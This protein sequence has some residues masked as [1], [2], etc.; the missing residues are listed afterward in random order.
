MHSVDRSEGQA[1]NADTAALADP[2]GHGAAEKAAAAGGLVLLTLAA[3]QFLMALDSSVMNV[4]IA[5]VANDV[6]TTV[7]GI[8]TAI[9]LY[10][11]VM[12]TTM[13]VGGKIGALIGRRRAFAIGC[14][15]YGAGSLTTALAPNLTVLLLGWSL[16]EGLGA[17]LIM[18][19]I[20]A[21][22]AANFAA[23]L[24]P[25][26]YGLVAAAGAMAIAVG[27][28]LGG[29]VTT[30]FSWRW[31]FAGEVVVVIGI[32]ALARRIHDRPAPGKV[33]LDVRGAVLSACGLAL[34][35]FGVLRSS[36]WGWVR[37]KAGAP[38]LLGLSPTLW[39]VLA[40]GLVLW[41]FFWWQ[42]RLQDTGREPLVSPDLLANRQL[43]GGLVMF[44]FQFLV[45]MGVFFTVPLF[46]SVVLGLTALQ[47]GLRLLPLSIALLIA[48]AGIPRLFPRV[49]PRLI[50]RLGLSSMLAGTVVLLAGIDLDASAAVVLLPMLLVG[51][52]IGALAS[53]L[54]SV[55]V[56]AVPDD[57]S[58]EVGGVQN[59]VTNLG[60][61]FGTALAGSILIAVL[62][63]SFI[64]GI[65]Q[66]PAVPDEVKTQ[67]S[68]ELA[69]GVPFV[70]DADLE[71]ALR[72][73][74]ADEALTQSVVADNR[75]ARVDGLDAALAVIALIALIG[76]F[77]TR[78]VPA[79]QPGAAEADGAP[80]G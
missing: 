33:H 50:A 55:T 16:L 30:Y 51:L 21:L 34:A 72:E 14:L 15:I 37:P 6:G 80:Q 66:N 52:G 5:N 25:R 62:T 40:G 77:F 35:V 69:G 23:A 78:M 41:L 71:T 12:A 18:P 53:Q 58:A 24:R 59:T 2:Q 38:E 49:S 32:L 4:S 13:I 9:T 44:F 8:Q 26:A 10:T 46:L 67:A 54:G 61:S 48:A 65:E 3:S 68:V 79:R 1:G 7:T 70:S 45:Q 22:I 29:L 27:P 43:R 11:L 47:T 75:K 56:S 60:A 31:V 57:K 63:A 20:V 76:L 74:G 39:L 28:L 36:E 73:A 19:A 64:Q 42:T 17:A